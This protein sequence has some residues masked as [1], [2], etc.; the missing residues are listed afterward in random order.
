VLNSVH[1]TAPE[2]GSVEQY[3]RTLGTKID[4]FWSRKKM[5]IVHRKWNCT[6]GRSEISIEVFWSSRLFLKS[7]MK[8]VSIF[9]KR[10][11][12]KWQLGPL[13]MYLS[14]IVQLIIS[15]LGGTALTLCKFEKC[16]IFQWH[17]STMY[18]ERGYT[19]N[20]RQVKYMRQQ[21]WKNIIKTMGFEIF[22][23]CIR[24]TS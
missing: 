4:Q 23:C 10:L 9:W 7:K 6:A 5:K 22:E 12:Q 1:C 13:Y 2:R 14:L 20:S 8:Q 17:L 3:Q 18:R 11:T 15:S 19:A 21:N 16:N 24:V